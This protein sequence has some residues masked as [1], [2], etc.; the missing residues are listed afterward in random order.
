MTD[1]LSKMMSS[2]DW[3]LADGATGTTLFNMGLSAGDA[4]EFWN[5]DH[6]DRVTALY[7]GSVDAGVDVFH[8]QCSFTRGDGAE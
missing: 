4:P 8:I 7:Q 6:K 5:V 3:I 1:P 2:R